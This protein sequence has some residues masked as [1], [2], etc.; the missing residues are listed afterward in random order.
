MRMLRMLAFQFRQFISVPY[1]VQ[2][3]LVATLTTT[4]IQYLAQRAWGGVDPTA[5][6]LRGGSIGMWTTVTAAAG[7]V[8][9]E[10][11]KGTL[12]QLVIAPIGALKAVASVVSAAA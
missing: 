9:F 12:V 10:R 7:I 6:W 3:L 8:G 4:L 1:F 5:A 11:F 2:L